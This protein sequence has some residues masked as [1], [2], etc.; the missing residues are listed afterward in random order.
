M[1]DFRHPAVFLLTCHPFAFLAQGFFQLCFLDAA[2]VDA[3]AKVVVEPTKNIRPVRSAMITM[4]VL[5]IIVQ[6][7]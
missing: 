3:V 7:R 4:K 1:P 6:F 5:G 2:G